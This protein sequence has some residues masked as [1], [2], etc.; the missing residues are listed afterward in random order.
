MNKVDEDKKS[1]ELQALNKKLYQEEQEKQE[2]LKQKAAEDSFYQKLLDGFDVNVLIVRYR[3]QIQVQ[4]Q[5]DSSGLSNYRH[6]FGPL[7][8]VSLQ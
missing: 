4:R 2:A 6:I 8:K 3:R 1:A 7:T 5:M